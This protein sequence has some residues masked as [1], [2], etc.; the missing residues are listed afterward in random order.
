VGAKE[1]PVYIQQSGV[2][3]HLGV[4]KA[5]V[6]MWL[7]RFPGHC[8][9]HEKCRPSCS[10]CQVAKLKRVPAPDAFAEVNTS[11]GGTRHAPLWLPE[12]LTEWDDWMTLKRW[13]TSADPHRTN[14]D[15]R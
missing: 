12:R 11:T 9:K 10:N 13:Q 4:G 15:V 7:R 8:D 3:L 1:P 2:A 5:A 14:Q 6:G